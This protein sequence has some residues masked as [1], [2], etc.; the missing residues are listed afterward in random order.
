MRVLRGVLLVVACGL[1][2]GALGA[3]A[4][5]RRIE[6]TGVV[7]VGPD[8]RRSDSR[9]AAV[10]A[11]IAE[12]V[13][14]VAAEELS[15]LDPSEARAV[16]RRIFAGQTRR[17]VKGFRVMEDRGRRAALL[18]QDPEVEREYV[19]LVEATVDA[20]AVR[21]RLVQAGLLAPEGAGA[22]RRIRLTLED[23]PS[24][25]AYEAVRT[26]LVERLRAESAL[27]V[28]FAHRRGVLEVTTRVRPEDLARR[29]ARLRL[30]GLVLEPRASGGNALSMA[31]RSVPAN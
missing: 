24:Y 11:G 21:T 5:E 26:A 25:G 15:A 14:R 3:G 18:I 17:H 4:E 28:E 16:S 27:P 10:A 13:Y 12:A 31:V 23:L 22:L 9:D 2:L 29:L 30:E 19:V 20:G 6:A 1:S 7:A 8:A